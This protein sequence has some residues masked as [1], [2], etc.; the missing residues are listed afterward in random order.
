MFSFSL[1][2]LF[3]FLGFFFRG[4]GGLGWLAGNFLTDDDTSNS[5]HIPH[6]PIQDVMRFS[7]KNVPT[8]VSAIPISL[9][10]DRKADIFK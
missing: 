10:I 1:S 6:C 4:G 5:S 2:F 7:G 8:L 9:N 3:S